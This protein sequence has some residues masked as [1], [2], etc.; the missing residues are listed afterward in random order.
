VLGA[1]RATS[2]QAAR[3][4]EKLGAI[5]NDNRFRFGM[6]SE[7]DVLEFAADVFRSVWAVELMLALK[8]RGDRAW[9]PSEIIKELRGSRVVVKEA[10][11]NLIA[12]G[13]VIEEDAGGYRYHASSATLDEMATELEKLYALK[14]MSV[15]HRIV[16][17]PSA[18]LQILSDAFRIKE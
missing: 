5:R 8:R 9:S 6:I 10:L 16:T 7:E 12:A 15:V 1:T 11:S 14:P 2:G 4:R 18:K 17:S 13:L 3:R